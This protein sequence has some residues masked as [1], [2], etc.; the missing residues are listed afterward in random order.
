MKLMSR[1]SL[2]ATLA[3]ASVTLPATRAAFAATDFP[4]RAVRIAVGFAPGGTTDILARIIADKLRE[5]WGVSVIVENRPGAD[6]IIA[7]TAVF[8]APADGYT[9]LMSTNAITITPHMK[10][11][12]YDPVKDFEPITIV[13]QEYH[14]L[15]VTPS[16]PVKT[17]REFIDLAKSTPKGL[18]FASAGPGSAPFLAMQRFMQAAGITNMVHVPFSGSAPALQAV[19]T[20]DVQAL[21]SSPSTTLQMALAGKVR[22]IGVAGPARD[23]NVP[24]IPTIAESALPGFQSNTWFALMA[25]A[26]VPAEVLEKIRVDAIRAMH[27][28][29]VRKRILGAGSSPVGNSAEEFR[30]VIKDDLEVYRQIVAKIK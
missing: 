2:L 22:I 18:T 19:V 28:P 30:K 8:Q 23:P 17:A 13:G 26:K 1:R 4:T 21:F 6:G 27:D 20:G 5:Y 9:L 12:P 25:S 11:L 24:D 14:H 10:T 29:D 7:T 15:M 16:L 3:G